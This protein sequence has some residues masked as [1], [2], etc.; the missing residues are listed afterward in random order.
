MRQQNFAR[1]AAVAFGSR[2]E[3]SA[4]QDHRHR[5]LVH[6]RLARLEEVCFLRAG[7]RDTGKLR[8][9]NAKPIQEST[10]THGRVADLCVE[11][12]HELIDVLVHRVAEAFECRAL[13]FAFRG[14]QHRQHI[15]LFACSEASECVKQ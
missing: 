15:V 5:Q 11:R 2:L 3:Q 1:P 6:L 10:P 14:R 8:S 4:R 12:Q 13:A 9:R 7:A